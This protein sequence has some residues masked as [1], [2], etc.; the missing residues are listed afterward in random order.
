MVYKDTQSIL[1]YIKSIMTLKKIK[2]KDLAQKL[3]LSQA[4]LSSRLNQ[5]NISFNLLIEICEA[6]GICMDIK[7]EDKKFTTKKDDGE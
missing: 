7:F 3:N 1:L 2:N 6:L 4:A 5:D